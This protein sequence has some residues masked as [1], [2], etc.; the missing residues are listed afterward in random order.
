MESSFLI[1]AALS[2][3]FLFWLLA[4]NKKMLFWFW[5]W[6]VKEY[7]LGRMREHFRTE[8]GK[9]VFQNPFFLLKLLL[10]LSFMGIFAL[11]TWFLFAPVGALGILTLSIVSVILYVAEGGKA[12]LDAQ[13]GIW[14][15]PVLTLK[16]K[17][18]AV[19]LLILN[20]GFIT[21]VILMNSVLS[22][23]SLPEV[24]F[25]VMLFPV[26][27]LAIDLLIPTLA[28][29]IVGMTHAGTL[30]WRRRLIQRAKRKRRAH[31]SL[32]VIGITGSYGKTST[33]EFLAFLLE[34][35]FGKGKVMKTRE[36]RNSEVGVSST[37]L[38]ELNGDHEVFVCEMAAYSRGG[39][40]LL[41]DI[42]RPQ[43]GV[44]T[45]VNEQHLGVFGSMENLLSAE[46]GRELVAALPQGGVAVVNADSERASEAIKGKDVR[47]V[48][49][50]TGPGAQMRGENIIAGEEELS[51]ELVLPDGKRGEVRTPLRGAQNVT[52]LLMAATA[53]HECGMGFSEI[54]EG[55]SSLTEEYDPVRMRKSP[56]GW[57]IMDASYSSNPDGAKS[58]LEYLRGIAGKKAVVMPCLIE[59]GE[60]ASFVHE[61][62]GRKI[63]PSCD[64]AVI[65]TRDHFADLKRTAGEKVVFENDPGTI[66]KKLRSV[67]GQEGTVLLEGRSSRDIIDAIF[68]AE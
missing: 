17:A 8:S 62:L 9:R 48:L 35:K 34:R 55:L 68:H 64:I 11:F 30:V 20:L 41:A 53:A 54:L 49:C 29:L 1:A 60:R 44:V 45:G 5:L 38:E 56:C 37:L 13:R 47:A 63:D 52:N 59:L 15:V 21:S 33:K 42:A 50:G 26:V 16:G 10:F 39:I 32:R 46:G 18:M 27:L 24:M 67:L 66:V 22:R 36:H 25:L 57:K 3:L 4:F 51:F 14:K 61:E 6:Q 7:H 19:M 28:I 2:A 65:T 12:L 40:A 58:H 43:I 23:I 31:P